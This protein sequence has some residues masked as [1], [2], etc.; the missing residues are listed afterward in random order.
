M[1]LVTN[2]NTE[3][4]EL[5]NKNLN[6]IFV[7]FGSSIADVF[8]AISRENFIN[9]ASNSICDSDLGLV[10]RASRIIPHPPNSPSLPA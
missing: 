7:L 8:V 9:N 6:F 4:F 10:C 2:F 3:S 5:I 1:P